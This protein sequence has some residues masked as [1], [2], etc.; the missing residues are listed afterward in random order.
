MSAQD[1]KRR[2]ADSTAAALSKPFR[3]PFRATPGK[4][5]TDS[6]DQPSDLGRTQLD[7]KASPLKVSHVPRARNP[8]HFPY[9]RQRGASLSSRPSDTSDS[10]LEIA[11]L[12][13]TQR[14]LKNKLHS[15]S[16]E[17]HLC[18]QAHKIEHAP[19]EA[20]SDGGEVGGELLRL[21]ERWKSASRQAAEE[22]FGS[23]KDKI[24]RMGGPQAWKEMQ[25]KQLEFQN[26]FNA[27]FGQDRRG[28]MDGD[29][30]RSDTDIRADI[31]L[32]T[33]NERE[34]RGGDAADEDLNDN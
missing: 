12:V 8:P 7:Q 22:L 9:R 30:G 32:E 13:K 6:Q 23:A 1:A 11:A 34:A 4:P 17:L 18:E 29:D 15:L 33:E 27:G 20:G 3:S 28:E 2:R 14:Q 16:E 19:S 5:N 26:E 25:E 21:T 31:E 10:Q 24:N